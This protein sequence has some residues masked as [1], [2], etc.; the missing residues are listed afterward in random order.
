MLT[1]YQFSATATSF[2]VSIFSD[3]NFRVH[4]K[5]ILEDDVRTS[6]H[7]A[8]LK[9]QIIV[10]KNI[11]R[12]CWTNVIKKIINLY[13][14]HFDVIQAVQWKSIHFRKQSICM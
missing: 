8:V 12:I 6:K 14:F 10:K 2:T 13:I 3:C 9:K 5:K 7:V 11:F 4:N 1:I